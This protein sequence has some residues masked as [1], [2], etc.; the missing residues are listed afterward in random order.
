MALCPKPY[1]FEKHFAAAKPS[2]QIN[3]NNRGAAKRG[4]EFLYP[5]TS[6]KKICLQQ[7]RRNDFQLNNS[8]FA[9]KYY[10][11]SS[12]D[13]DSEDEQSCYNADQ[14]RAKR[15]ASTRVS[16]SIDP[17]LSKAISQYSDDED[18]DD[19]QERYYNTKVKSPSCSRR[20]SDSSIKILRSED[21]IENLDCKL[22]SSPVNS[23]L[24]LKKMLVGGGN[25]CDD[26]DEEEEEESD[27]NNQSVAVAD[28]N[29]RARCFEYLVGA[30]DEA[31]ARYCDATA[32]VE[33]EVHGY[34]TPASLASGDD[35]DDEDD[36]ELMNVKC[37]LLRSKDFLQ[38]HIESFDINDVKKFWHRWDITKYQM[39]D[40]MEDEDDVLEE[41]ESGRRVF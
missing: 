39:L 21:E 5:S 15:R 22:A 2:S 6:N 35:E 30:I 19:V 36:K 17:K 31:W 27:S 12:D 28:R 9:N 24:S 13:D 25:E 41:L 26:D 20:T 16:F 34:I 8:D 18:E 23:S 38:D 10:S 1:T 40:V 37:R 3:N 32:Y 14:I 4:C 33:D 7:L 29:A 11:S